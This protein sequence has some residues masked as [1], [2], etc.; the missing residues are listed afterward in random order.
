MDLAEVA[1]LND[2][3]KWPQNTFQKLP[4]VIQE[5]LFIIL[6]LSIKQIEH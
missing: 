3:T 5:P 4:S 1:L 6:Y 2:P